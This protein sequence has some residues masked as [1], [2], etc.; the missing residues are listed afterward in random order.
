MVIIDGKK[1]LIGVEVAAMIHRETYNV[2]RSLKMKRV[3]LRRALQEQIEVL[4]DDRVIA[5]GTHSVTFIPYAEGLE[6]I[7]RTY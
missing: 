5:V 3:K 6:F 2:Y 7:F 1:F 4:T